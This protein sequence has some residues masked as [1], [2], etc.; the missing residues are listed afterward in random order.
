M[1]VLIAS[2]SAD[3]CILCEAS[4]LSSLW[5]EEETAQIQQRIRLDSEL[6]WVLYLHNSSTT[7]I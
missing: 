7:Q 2:Q 5:D 1:A 4:P 3:S 6:L